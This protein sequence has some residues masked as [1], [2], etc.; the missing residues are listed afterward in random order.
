MNTPL[1]T[2]DGFPRSDIDVAQ[3]RSTRTQIIRR[4]ND[5]KDVMKHLEKEMH[6]QYAQVKEQQRQAED[7]AQ[8]IE[9]IREDTEGLSISDPST[10]IEQPHQL[11]VPFASV[12]SVAPASPAFTAVRIF[13]DVLVWVYSLL[14]IIL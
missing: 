7:R 11:L 12:N 10:S 6:L 3:V 4:K 8:T 2:P 9:G 1:V 5:L 14:T 13:F